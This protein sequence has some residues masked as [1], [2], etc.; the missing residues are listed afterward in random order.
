METTPAAL[1]AGLAGPASPSNAARRV[2][3]HSCREG[4][5]AARLHVLPE[6]P[7]AV[8]LAAQSHQRTRRA[9]RPATLA[10]PAILHNIISYDYCS[11]S[12][13]HH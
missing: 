7:G 2:V 9:S 5:R 6:D 10:A 13:N 8:E 1:K 3:R 12:I 4:F 11:L